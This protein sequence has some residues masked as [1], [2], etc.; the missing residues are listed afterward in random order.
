[1]KF[2]NSREAQN[3]DIELFS[4]YKYSLDQLVELAGWA[5]AVATAKTYPIE[6][7]PQDTKKVLV[8]C[9][10]GNNGGDGLVAAR[11]LKM[12]GY[13]PDIY[14]PECPKGY[15]PDAY[16]PK[17][18]TKELFRNLVIQAKRQSITF[19]E[20]LPDKDYIQ[21]KY[22]FVVDAL[23]GFAYKGDLRPPYTCCLDVIKDINIPLI[24]VDVPSGWHIER[25]NPDGIKPDVLISLIAPKL[26]AAKFRG[27]YHFLGGRFVP[28]SLED[29][30]HLDLPRFPGTECVALLPK[31]K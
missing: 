3:I 13:N 4:E 6:T 7:L 27:E 10:P 19:I 15:R 18:P 20:E 17:L 2:L 28:K 29:K 24:S 8:I 22:N 31:I 11:H 25:A 23:F 1:M 16:F 12:F 5:V 14:Y 30:Y 21:A 9:G 26:C